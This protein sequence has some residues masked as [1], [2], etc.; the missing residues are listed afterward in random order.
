M[1]GRKNDMFSIEEKDT[2]K[3]SRMVDLAHLAANDRAALKDGF[4]SFY[5][6]SAAFKKIIALFS[7][8]QKNSSVEFTVLH[9]NT[10]ENN[11]E[12]LSYWK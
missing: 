8:K 12:S 3:H 6:R 1:D 10:H 7:G 4:W 2:L 5:F 9:S 11:A